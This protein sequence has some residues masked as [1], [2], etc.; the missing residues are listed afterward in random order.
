MF[1]EAHRVHRAYKIHASVE[2]VMYLSVWLVIKGV[3]ILCS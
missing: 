3:F 2:I 1:H